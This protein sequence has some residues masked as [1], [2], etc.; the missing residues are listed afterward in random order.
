M[1]RLQT[2]RKMDW[3]MRFLHKQKHNIMSKNVTEILICQKTTPGGNQLIQFC[4]APPPTL[5]PVSRAQGRR[6]DYETTE[7]IMSCW[8]KLVSVHAYM[9]TI[10]SLAYKS[11]SKATHHPDPL[12]AILNDDIYHS[13]SCRE[14]G[15]SLL[16]LRQLL[17]PAQNKTTSNH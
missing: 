4:P 16:G 14:L 2:G 5:Q 1:V 3:K 15:H 7:F 9:M 11:N 10:P 8:P 12:P 6:S 13:G 17:E